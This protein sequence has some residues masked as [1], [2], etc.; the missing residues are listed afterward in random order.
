ML[1]P[2]D[3]SWGSE[4]VLPSFHQ[5][6]FQWD[7]GRGLSE[8]QVTCFQGT[9]ETSEKD[10]MIFKNF[11]WSYYP[12]A[13]YLVCAEDYQNHFFSLLYPVKLILPSKR[14]RL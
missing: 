8:N 12:G 10:H 1:V 5:N 3:Y 6:S 9:L 4:E 2:K 14:L 11:L 13:N 7:E